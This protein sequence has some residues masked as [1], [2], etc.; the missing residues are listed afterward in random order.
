MKHITNSIQTRMQMTIIWFIRWWQ[1]IRRHPI[2]SYSNSSKY[3]S[4]PRRR[5]RYRRG[6]PNSTPEWW[7]L[8]HW[9]N[10]SQNIVHIWTCLTTQTMP[11]S[12]SLC[13]LPN[14]LICRQFGFKWHFLF[15]RHHG[16]VE[17]RGHTI[18]W[19]YA[20]LEGDW[21]DLNITLT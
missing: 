19:R 17:Q 7:S 16:N 10:T 13:K 21:F 8:D 6:L 12:M 14:S 15:W 20:V 9:G 2:N 4:I 11:V 18:T 1:H 3:Y 5:G